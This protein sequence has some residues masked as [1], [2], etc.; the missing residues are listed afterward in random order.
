[1]FTKNKK[2]ILDGGSGQTL[3]EMG[4]KPEGRLMKNKKKTKQFKLFK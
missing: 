3:L 4:L 2:Y 1:M